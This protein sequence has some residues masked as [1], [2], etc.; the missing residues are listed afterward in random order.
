MR[1]LAFIVT[2]ILIS[3]LPAT[4]LL[5]LWLGSFGG[6]NILDTAHHG[7]FVAVTGIFSVLGFIF[8]AV[9]AS[10]DEWK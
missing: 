9:V 7:N 8:G 6:F 10:N 3:L 4:F 5:I 2:W 1:L